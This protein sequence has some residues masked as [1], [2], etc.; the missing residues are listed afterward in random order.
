MM[1][2]ILLLVLTLSTLTLATSVNDSLTLKNYIKLFS[3]LLDINVLV[4]KDLEDKE[5]SFYLNK[6][7]EQI[8]KDIGFL[9]DVL[10]ANNMMLA[11]K[12]NYYIVV[13]KNELAQNCTYQ[14]NNSSFKD[15]ENYFK[16]QKL[17]YS[18]FKDSNLVYFKTMKYCSFHTKKLKL[19]DR[20]LLNKK[21]TISLFQNDITKNKEKEIK[22]DTKYLQILNP[23]TITADTKF[24]YNNSS[25]ESFLKYVDKNSDIDIKSSPT[26]Q[27]FNN[28]EIAFQSFQEI[29]YTK[30]TTELDKD[31]SNKTTESTEFKNVGIDVK[32]KPRFLK[33]GSILCDMKLSF[34]NFIDFDKKG[35][36]TTYTN[37][38]TTSFILKDKEMI[39]LS[40]LN[41]ESNKNVLSY[42]L[43]SKIPI[44]GKAFNGYS[45]EYKK[46]HL[47]LVVKL[48]N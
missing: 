30:I 41:Q 1:K 46:F 43:L 38:V 32:I 20:A 4:P 23:F 11:K 10:Q 12:E 35:V 45:K 15:I 14:I 5:I 21:L 29:P 42:P 28:K 24:M 8:E 13:E 48:S 27:I 44:V 3:N 36:P 7:F 25:Y 6:D 2:K 17:K 37:D 22:I 47:S 39:V 33:D 9:S 40:G 18:L 26:F 34:S 31:N 16:F 19:I